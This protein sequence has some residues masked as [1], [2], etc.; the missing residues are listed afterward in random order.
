MEACRNYHGPILPGHH[1]ESMR[2]VKIV[3]D[4]TDSDNSILVASRR[5]APSAGKYQASGSGTKVAAAIGSGTKQTVA[6]GSGTKLAAASSTKWHK[7][8]PS[9]TKRHRLIL[10]CGIGMA[11]RGG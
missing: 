7:P 5:P 2:W 1:G 3:I 10:K 4:E 8:T 11:T 6:S 9:D